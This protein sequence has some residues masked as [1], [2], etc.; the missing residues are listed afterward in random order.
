MLVEEDIVVHHEQPLPLDELV[1]RAGLE[2]DDIVGTR[3][4]VVAP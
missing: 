1:E 2:T 4:D 3:R